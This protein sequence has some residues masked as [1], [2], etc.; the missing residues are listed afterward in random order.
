MQIPVELHAVLPEYT[1]RNSPHMIASNFLQFSQKEVPFL[2]WQ[3]HYLKQT[4]PILYLSYLHL[5]NSMTC[6]SFNIYVELL[7]NNS[8]ET[9]Y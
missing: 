7:L 3:T 4:V 1:Y 2:L 6:N 5:Q 9:I 8:T